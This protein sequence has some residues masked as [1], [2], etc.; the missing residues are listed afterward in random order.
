MKTKP[1]SRALGTCGEESRHSGRFQLVKWNRTAIGLPNKGN[2][3][4]ES[5]VAR[6]LGGQRGQREDRAV[7]GVVRLY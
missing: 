6:D 5:P 4:L 2:L 3:K 7:G 1:R